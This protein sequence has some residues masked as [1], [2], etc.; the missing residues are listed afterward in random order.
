MRI[1]QVV[2][3]I[4]TTSFD[5]SDLRI[6]YGYDPTII[7]SLSFERCEIVNRIGSAY[8][9][10]YKHVQLHVLTCHMLLE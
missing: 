8:H 10:Q 5:Q 6:C 7:V 4:Y 2:S 1:L 9:A 3:G